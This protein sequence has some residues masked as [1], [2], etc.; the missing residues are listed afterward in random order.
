MSR[1]TQT[2]HET[3]RGVNITLLDPSAGDKLISFGDI[4]YTQLEAFAALQRF[5]FTEG[6]ALAFMEAKIAHLNGG[7]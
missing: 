1:I 7:L 5:G 2:I 3:G 4:V 6:E